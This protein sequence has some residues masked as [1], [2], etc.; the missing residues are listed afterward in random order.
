[1][2]TR[3]DHVGIVTADIASAVDKY[4]GLMHVPPSSVMRIPPG[5]EGFEAAL[6]NLGNVLVEFLQVNELKAESPTFVKAMKA[7]GE[8]LFHLALFVRDYEGEIQAWRDRGHAVEEVVVGGENIGG[9]LRASWIGPEA[10]GGF[11]IE[12]VDEETIPDS[13]RP[14]DC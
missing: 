11:W 1:M 5:K 2:Y 7:N 8:G 9:T 3:L 6:I 13:L 4:C 12:I 14:I 10:T